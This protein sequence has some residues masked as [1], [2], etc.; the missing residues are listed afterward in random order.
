VRRTIVE[1]LRG[2]GKT[3]GQLFGEY[4]KT[5]ERPFLGDTTFFWYLE[6]MG[7][8]VVKDGAGI[9]RLLGDS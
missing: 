1:L 8:R 4:Q 9:W 6:R 3:A 7:P 2:G 5:E